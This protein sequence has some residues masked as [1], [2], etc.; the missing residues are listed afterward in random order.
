M[1]NPEAADRADRPDPAA[2]LP[3][4]EP[5]PARH[6][7]GHAGG[8]QLGSRLNDRRK[9]RASPGRRRRTSGAAAA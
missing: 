4:A 9:L 6:T 3:A 5:V 2:T 1:R 7:P 8:S